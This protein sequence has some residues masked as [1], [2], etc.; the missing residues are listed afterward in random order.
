MSQPGEHFT[1]LGVGPRQLPQH[2][3]M[4]LRQTSH[5][6]RT[7]RLDRACAAVASGGHGFSQA[8]QRADNT[9]HEKSGNEH[10]HGQYNGQPQPQVMRQSL[11]LKTGRRQNQPPA[12][13]TGHET[14]PQTAALT[15]TSMAQDHRLAQNTAEMRGQATGKTKFRFMLGNRF[16]VGD[17][18]EPL[19]AHVRLLK[20]ATSVTI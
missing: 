18:L 16:A 2:G 4:A 12:F 14:N 6:L 10:Q 3:V 1:T 7:F 9:A 8:R 20:T 13:A 11:R 15:R 17:K 5:L 19:L